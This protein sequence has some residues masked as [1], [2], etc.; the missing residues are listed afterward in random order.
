VL[1]AQELENEL[2]IMRE[3]YDALEARH[4][5]VQVRNNPQVP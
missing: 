4:R 3:S 5:T 2:E 1:C